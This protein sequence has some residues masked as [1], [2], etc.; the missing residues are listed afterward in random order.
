MNSLGKNRFGSDV[1]LRIAFMIQPK[2]VAIVTAASA[3]IGAA[4]SLELANRGYQLVIMARSARIHDVAAQ[5]GGRAVEGSITSTEDL[6]RLVDVALSSFGAINAVVNN[7]GNPDGGELLAISDAH[8]ESVFQMYLL[9]IIR[10]A[11]KITPVMAAAGGGAFVN[12]SGNDALE[13]SLDFPV[14]STIRASMTAFTK[15]FARRYAAQNIRMNCVSPN[16]VMDPSQASKR[17]DLRDGL[18]MRRP[19]RYDEVAKVVAFLLSPDA[20]YVSGEDV[21]VDGAASWSV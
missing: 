7:S 4:C 12:I 18:P 1:S 3:G 11:R 19:A 16:V 10:L 8:W 21:R 5:C 14:A 13:P 15:L 9:S 6:S 17:T 2:P 20:S